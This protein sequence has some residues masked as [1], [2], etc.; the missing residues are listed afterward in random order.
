LNLRVVG[1]YMDGHY[2]DQ[3]GNSCFKNL[4]NVQT[5]LSVDGAPLQRQPK[6]QVRATPS[7]TLP[8][9]WGDATAW[10]TYEYS[11]QRYEDLFG[12]QPLG[13]YSMVSAG[14]LTDIGN[15]WQFRIQGTNLNNEIALTEGNA[16][17]AGKA[18]GIDGVLMARPMEG[19][20]INFTVY[21]KF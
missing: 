15:H 14:F 3:V 17:Q 11:G 1:D 21:Y 12:Q 2:Q 13:S 7:Y 5:C 4:S 8:F 16:R 20:E 6:F 18:T 19:R 10:V 9:S